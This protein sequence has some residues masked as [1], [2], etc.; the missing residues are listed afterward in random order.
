MVNESLK[1]DRGD[2]IK[3]HGCGGEGTERRKVTRLLASLNLNVLRRLCT[4]PPLPSRRGEKNPSEHWSRRMKQAAGRGQERGWAPVQAT[5]RKWVESPW[6][7]SWRGDTAGQ[8]LWKTSF[9][10]IPHSNKGLTKEKTEK[11]SGIRDRISPATGWTPIKAEAGTG[12]LGE[13]SPAL[14]TWHLDGWKS[15]FVERNPWVKEK[16]LCSPSNHGI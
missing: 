6:E 7:H 1:C 16:G 8:S 4:G 15:W 5:G 11:A 2:E 9:Q 13:Q 12:K 14:T 3:N 10:R